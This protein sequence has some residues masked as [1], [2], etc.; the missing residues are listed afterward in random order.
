MCGSWYISVLQGSAEVCYWLSG[1][2]SNN[3]NNICGRQKSGR[4]PRYTPV[5]SFPFE[6]A[7]WNHWR[8]KGIFLLIWLLNSRLSK[9]EVNPGGSDLI[10]WALLKRAKL[11]RDTP[12]WPQGR[13]S[14]LLL[15]GGEQKAR[16]GNE[17]RTLPANSQWEK[18]GTQCW[19]SKH[20]I[21]PTMCMSL[22]DPGVTPAPTST[23]ISACLDPEQ[24]TQLTCTQTP[25]TQ[26]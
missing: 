15:R 17:L 25:K 21:W 20:W 18:K 24:R 4:L 2:N 22:E 10:R 5:Q 26:K 8:W 14:S 11:Q 12:Q 3:T 7:W 6:S 9:S 19:N 13:N 23:L 16:P 1:I